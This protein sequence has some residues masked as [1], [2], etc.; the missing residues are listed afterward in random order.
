M[1]D[2]L[3]P[4]WLELLDRQAGI[5]TRSQA[6]GYGFNDKAVD[7][8]MRSARWRALHRGVYATFSGTPGRNAELWAAVLCAGSGAALSHHT[9]AELL[10]LTDKPSSV[11]HITVPPGRHPDPIRGALIHRYRRI[12]QSTHPAQLPPRTRVEETVIDLTQV[13]ASLDDA[14][15]WLSGAVGRRLTTAISLRSALD[16]RPKVRWRAEL[17]HMLADIATGVHSL[18][19]HRYIRDV[20]RAHGLP[21]AIRQVKTVLGSRSRY[22]DN[23]YAKARLVVELDGQV[24]HAAQTRWDDVHRDN[25]HA[26][27][28]IVTLRY[29]WSDITLRPCAVAQ[30]IAEVLER[31]GK[32][33]AL[34]RCGPGCAVAGPTGRTS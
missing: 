9:A 27:I 7:R 19:E 6:K 2:L 34:R 29:S 17:G 32:R 8:E 21:T 16:S 5:V 15:A 14:C 24:A 31:R 33:V 3:L 1:S 30:E 26:T 25:A 13:S 18:L 4:D 23:L 28:G 20:E 12:A 10:G 11:I 22:V